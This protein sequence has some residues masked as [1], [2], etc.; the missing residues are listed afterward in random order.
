MGQF[1][2]IGLAHEIIIS[3][4]D[5]RKKMISKEEL[6]QEIEQTLLFDLN[7]YEETETD[8]VL[9]FAIKDQVLETELIPFLEVL[10]PMVYDEE[11]EWESLDL[12]KQLH[13]TPST[14]WIDLA[15]EKSNSAFQYD[16][17]AE[18]RYIRIS[19]AFHPSI[20]LY[21]NCLMLYMGKGKIS[22]EG[23][24]DFLD[25]FKH[26]IH[27]TYKEHPIVKSIQVYVTG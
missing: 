14:K 21:F 27:E 19:K 6:R 25:F 16:E 2:T 1:L 17:Y 13:S 9:L 26:C 20:C 24:D 3:R 15:K 22:T 4:D 7:L 18:P 23:L 11:D 12:L 10:Y 5:L 8:E